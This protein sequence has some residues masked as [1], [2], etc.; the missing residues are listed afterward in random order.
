MTRGVLTCYN[1]CMLTV[2]TAYGSILLTVFLAATAL[3]GGLYYAS[4]NRDKFLPDIRERDVHKVRKSRIGGI[5]IW[6]SILVALLIVAAIPNTSHFLNFSRPYFGGLDIS[7]WGIIAGLSVLLVMG[8]IDDIKG[9]SPAA[10]L[11]GQFLASLC[12]VVAGIGVSHITLP[13]GGLLPLDQ[14]SWVL[15]T[16][17]GGQTIWLWSSL[18]TIIWTMTMINV[19]NWFD[20][21]D[22]LAGSVSVTA[23]VVLFFLSIK[24][25]FLS[26]ATLAIVLAAA[27]AGFLVWNW[28]PSKLFMG[29]VG[30]QSIGFVLAVI[31]IVSGGKV[32]T[33]TIVLGV[34][35][36]DALIV[37]IR[38]L[39]AGA[40]PFQADQ[41]HLHHRLLKMGLPV[42]WVVITINVVAAIFGL[43][44]YRAQQANAK[45]ALTLLL[46]ALMLVFIYLTYVFERGSKKA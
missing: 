46:V 25:G 18:F 38:R 29:T 7:L 9:L 34:P 30:S 15:P 44:A 36:F 6:F 33:A 13:F 22:G 3:T 11:L 17:L 8:L 42:P 20:G 39:V 28:Y 26:T 40:S 23:S 41:R 31:A 21:L 14:T 37:V 1:Q 35:L 16:W 2:P 45:G 12:L 19:M 4:R 27:S 10:Q 5:A 32:A 24:L 43:F